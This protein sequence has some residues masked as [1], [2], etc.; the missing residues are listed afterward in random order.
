M[1]SMTYIS[2][3][4]LT[5][6]MGFEQAVMTGLAP[7]GGLLVPK[8]IPDVRDQLDH[9][10]TLSYQDI[11]FEIMKL[12]VDMP[13]ADLRHL[14]EKSYA[15]FAHPEI[16]PAIPVGQ[17]QILELFHGPTLAFKDI[18]LQFLS[19][20]FEYYLGKE[21]HKLNILGATSGDTGSAA[22]HGVAGR[23]RMNIFIMHP[24]GRVSPLQEKQMTSVLD[25]NVFNIALEGTFDDGQRIMKTLFEDVTFKEKYS[26]GAINSVNWARVMA[27]IVYYFSAGLYV[28]NQAGAKKVRFA[29]PT[30]NF[31]DVLAGYY[32]KKMGLPVSLL[33]LA[34]N[35]N[36]IL[37]RFFARGE[38]SKGEVVPTISPSM[39]IQVASNFERYLFDR[40]GRDAEVLRSMM[41]SFNKTGRLTV[42][43]ESGEPVD[44]LFAAGV[45]N[46]A[47]TM[48]IIRRY[49]RE[50]GYLLDPHTAVGVHVAE[51]HLDEAE[52]MI[53]L[54]TAHPA[55]FAQAIDSAIG[56]DIARHP[57]L[58]ALRDAPTRS[59]TLP[60]D[61]KAVRKYIETHALA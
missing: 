55:K 41:N 33:V 37:A 59:V 58:E 39:D 31:G 14:I 10:A 12:F 53:C 6:E 36:D 23:D 61:V 40:V 34:T 22:I 13:E 52:P 49:Y 18:A 48:S 24:K 38:Y 4:G 32:A 2:T 26:L 35:E 11:T 16:A 25:A 57:A 20:F 54:A 1:K 21:N 7:D 60:N 17:I 15:P 9:W 19:N 27:Q 42:P 51:Q 43:V 3:R 44:P 30:G 56:E 47:S 46:T 29:V 5:P 28:L 8:W 45:G 50:Y